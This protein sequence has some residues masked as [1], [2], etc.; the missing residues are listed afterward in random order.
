MSKLA[1]AAG[2][3]GHQVVIVA[4]GPHNETTEEGGTRVV[5][6]AAPRMPYD[7]TYHWPWRVDRMRALVK[8]EQPE[9]LQVSSPFVA[10]AVA[11]TLREVPVRAYVHHSDPIGCYLEYGA[12]RYLPRHIADLAMAPAWRWMRT[13]CRSCD[14]T[15]VA[16]HWLEKVL[17]ARRCERVTTV[18]FGISHSDF[19]PGLRDAGL[20]R[21]L[22]G[23]LA[24]DP[25]ARL[26]LISGRLAVEK[27]QRLLLAAVKHLAR[28]RPLALT[29]LGDGPERERM[30]REARGMPA[31]RFLRFTQDRAK[32]AAVLASADALIHGS[33]CETFGFV[34]AETLASGTPIVVPDAGGAS[35]MA[36][37]SCSEKYPAFANAA[38]IASA[39]D[40]LL[41]R[42]APELERAAVLAAAQ[43]PTAE[44]H[45]DE[46]FQLYEQ[47]VE[48][49]RA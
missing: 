11:R 34:L 42:P 38:E 46:L 5:R 48:T 17:R 13:V 35:A 33:R 24:D 28:R 43:H 22:M 16:S 39:I 37:L 31:T 18:R 8:T 29:V 12:R 40:R 19:G 10:A 41:S 14:V 3:R 27:R 4:P 1:A 21:E 32:Y 44:E 25:E 7:P 15:I 47:L 36:P 26:L 30:E 49:K 9:V 23:P 45:F 6:Y 20:R 2:P